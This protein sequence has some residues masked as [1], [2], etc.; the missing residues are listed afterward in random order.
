MIG[1]FNAEQSTIL[2]KCSPPCQNG[3][4][5]L[6]SGKCKCPIEFHGKLCQNLS[7]RPRDDK[8]L[9]KKSCLKKPC[10][11][12]GTCNEFTGKCICSAGYRGRRCHR[13][14]TRGRKYNTFFL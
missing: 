10:Q 7:Q 11:N 14:Q 6:N 3:G 13:I 5:C 4:M 8:M 9:L 2:G 1:K 12:G